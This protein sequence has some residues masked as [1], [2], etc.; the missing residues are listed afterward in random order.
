MRDGHITHV[1]E[2]RRGQG[3]SL[4]HAGTPLGLLAWQRFGMLR[5]KALKR[6]L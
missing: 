5:E 2:G 4:S 1:L 3:P 6:F